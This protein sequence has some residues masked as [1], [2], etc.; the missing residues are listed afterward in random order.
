MGPA[1]DAGPR[2]TSG[3]IMS[4]V[5]WAFLAIGIITIVGAI[6][7]T[8]QSKAMAAV[9][10][11]LLGIVL[12]LA[13]IPTGVGVVARRTLD[14]K[15]AT[16]SW[17]QKI[18]F[19]IIG[20]FFI[21]VGLLF[22]WITFTEELPEALHDGSWSELGQALLMLLFGLIFSVGVGYLWVSAAFG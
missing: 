10:G 17:T 3:I 1:L 14:W 13:A 6:V 4:A 8:V 5:Q 20:P 12:L 7:S 2:F 11:Y 18:W 22:L 21:L 15:D 16:E 9:G 19:I